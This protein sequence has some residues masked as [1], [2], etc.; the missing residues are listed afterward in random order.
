MRRCGHP[1]GVVTTRLASARIVS[2]QQA[3]CLARIPARELNQHLETIPVKRSIIPE[4]FFIHGQN[5]FISKWSD[6]QLLGGNPRT[7]GVKEVNGVGFIERLVL[8]QEVENLYQGDITGLG[9]DE[10]VNALGDD[11]EPRAHRG[12]D[13]PD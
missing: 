11:R 3:Q 13:T 6:K 12:L 8:A 9:D 7:T 10:L 1:T 4:P 2:T 5:C